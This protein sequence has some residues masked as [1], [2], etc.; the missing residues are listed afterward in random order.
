MG[1]TSPGLLAV[2]YQ[3]LSVSSNGSEWVKLGL[4]VF[5]ALPLL[6]SV[7]SNGS[8]WVKLQRLK[9]Q[10]MITRLSVSSN[11]SEW[12]KRKRNIWKIKAQK[13]FS[14]LKRIG[15]GETFPDYYE[16]GPQEFLSVSSNGSEWVK[17]P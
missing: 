9:S 12:V 16:I 17:P 8:E 14:I 4:R 1:E 11:G 10:R 2:N 5:L 3:V 6:L 13:P 15:V 7:S